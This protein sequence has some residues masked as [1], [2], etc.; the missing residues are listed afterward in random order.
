MRDRLIKFLETC[1]GDRGDYGVFPDRIRKKD[2]EAVH[3]AEEQ[4]ARTG[5]AKCARIELVRLQTV[6]RCVVFECDVI[7]IRNVRP[8]DSFV[9]T[10]P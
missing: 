2:I 5:T 3:A 1:E 7:R 9:G 4:F 10:D 8:G 6:I